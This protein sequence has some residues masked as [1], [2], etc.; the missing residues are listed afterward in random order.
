MITGEAFTINDMDTIEMT[1]IT[2]RFGNTV[3]DLPEAGTRNVLM[4][5]YG[6]FVP[7][8]KRNLRKLLVDPQGLYLQLT[9]TASNS[10]KDNVIH[11]ALLNTVLCKTSSGGAFA[12]VALPAEQKIVA[13]GT[14]MITAKLIAAKAMFRRNEYDEQNGKPQAILR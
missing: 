8:E 5:D 12:P 4:A 10:K 6:V 1:Q 14:G 11:R 3:W 2:T 13:G 7:V 9:L